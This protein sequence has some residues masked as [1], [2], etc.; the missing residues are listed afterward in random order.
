LTH[1][2]FVTTISPAVLKLQ[3]SLSEKFNVPTFTQK[4]DISTVPSTFV[5]RINVGVGKFGGESLG[6]FTAKLNQSIGAIRQSGGS[7]GKTTFKRTVQNPNSQETN[8]AIADNVGGFNFGD[9]FGEGLSGTAGFLQNN[10][11]LLIVGLGVI[12]LMVLKK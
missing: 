10:P 9:T 12:A 7:I 8:A 11:T 3:Q 1:T 4:G 6:S 5:G 2:G